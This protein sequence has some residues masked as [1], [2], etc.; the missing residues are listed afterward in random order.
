M[1]VGV[2]SVVNNDKFIVNSELGKSVVIKM[3]I[4]VLFDMGRLSINGGDLGFI[5]SS[6]LCV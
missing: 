4:S 1:L 2:S 6:N 5:V 3:F